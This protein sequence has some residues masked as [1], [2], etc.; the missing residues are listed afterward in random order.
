MAFKM[1]A[2]KEGPMRKNFGKDIAPMNFNAGLRKASREGKLDNNPKFKAAVDNAPT[3]MITQGGY[4]G[5]GEKG[6][7]DPKTGKFIKNKDIKESVRKI[8]SK[9][10]TGLDTE[11]GKKLAKKAE[12]FSNRFLGEEKTKKIK[13]GIKNIGK[14]II[15]ETAPIARQAYKAKKFTRGK[16]TKEIKGTAKKINYDDVFKMKKESPKKFLGKAIKGVGKFAKKNP[17][18][19]GGLVGGPAGMLAGSLM[20]MKE[21]PV[22]SFAKGFKK[23]FQDS[24]TGRAIKKTQSPEYTKRMVKKFKKK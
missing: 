10:R 3:K 1:K 9:V 21:N 17:A 23:G 11:T 20:K 5:K 8:A 16:L 2:G 15:K 13:K 6:I 24:K 14:Q 7:I 22:K 4:T 18:L 12:A 19:A